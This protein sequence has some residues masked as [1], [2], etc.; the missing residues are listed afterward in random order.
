MCSMS[1]E[2]VN[3]IFNCVF[4][5]KCN[6][7][8]DENILKKNL[9]TERILCQGSIKHKA[10]QEN[11]QRV[12][13]FERLIQNI[14]SYCCENDIH[15]YFPKAYQHYPDMGHDVDLFIDIKG[16]KLI[17][18][19]HNFQLT[20]DKSSFLNGVA[21]KSPYLFDFSIPIETHRFAGH[22][23]EFKQLTQSFYDN[24]IVDRGVNQLCDEH[25]LL[26][27]IVQ[28]FYGHFTIRLTDIIYSINLLNK[29]VDLS[30]V[31]EEADKYGI[32]SALYEYLGFIFGNFECYIQSNRY[33]DFN[34]KKSKYIYFSS[35]MFV[36][37]RGF[38][39][40]LFLLKSL[41]DLM[42]FRIFALTRLLTAPLVLLAM[43]VRRIFN[44]G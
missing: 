37:N 1:V 25:K 42:H 4:H 5:Q 15:Y 36:V 7:V 38:A 44:K 24:L 27:Q 26:N 20:K 31:E 39:L 22:F 43:I 40:K 41:S 10:C 21:G 16:D 17:D 19:I 14:A 6:E 13:E 8:F 3:K 23:G 35:D 28:R 29:G 32:K 11:K 2:V 30:F 12:Y 34:K 33:S 18:F 9:L